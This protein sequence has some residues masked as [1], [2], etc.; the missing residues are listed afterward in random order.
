LV[1]GLSV[2]LV[3]VGLL[4]TLLG[5]R[6]V[7]AG[8]A[9]SAVGLI[10]SG[11]YLGYVLGTFLAP[12][13]IGRV[14]HIRAYTA[15]AALG[16][17]CTLAFG[18][19]VDP[20]AW[21]GLRVLSGFCVLGT[22]MV[23]ESWLNEQAAG[24][25]RG[26]VFALY[27][28]ATL[29]ALAAGQ[30][31]LLVGDSGGLVPFVLA[32]M[33]ISLGVIPIAVTRVREPQPIA[34]PSRGVWWLLAA[35]PL[36]F[37]GAFVAGVVGAGFWGLGA[38]FAQR[39]GMAS[40]E[41]AVFMSATILGGALL[42][43]PVGHLSDRLDR[44][45][46][47]VVVSFASAGVAATALYFLEGHLWGLTVCAFLYGGLMFS[48][49]PLCVA[50]AND[51][52]QPGQVLDGTRGLLLVYGLGALGGP[53]L[54]GVLMDVYGTFALPAGSAALLATLGVYGMYRVARRAAPPVA[55]QT[56]FVGMV[57][58]TP[59]V[60]EMHPDADPAPELDLERP[61]EG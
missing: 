54:L 23:V 4:G 32:S 5:V 36:G 26:R 37:V 40:P 50:H 9:N 7:M 24:P 45:W 13:L 53:A 6:G 59:V 21:G 27:M 42:Q 22:Y 11:Y 57:R 29:G 8:F 25:Q 39:A 30:G 43:W 55:E 10:G 49:Y 14:G 48:V 33:L 46:V 28:A 15:M 31:F 16:S 60:L 34:T 3:G 52:L 1:L 12:A 47:L 2:L 38:M 58:T 19:V 44:R 51:Q 35:S 18:L 17:V 20:W 61:G 41:I 56:A